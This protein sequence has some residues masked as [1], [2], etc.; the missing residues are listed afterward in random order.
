MVFAGPSRLTGPVLPQFSE[1]ETEVLDALKM[2]LGVS[3]D[4]IDDLFEQ[5]D[6][7]GQD[8]M[9][10]T[11]HMHIKEVEE[12]KDNMGGGIEVDIITGSVDKD[13]AMSDNE[14]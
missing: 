5:C 14:M 13:V 1:H 9:R 3:Q 4:K 8:F 2:G 6:H 11:F 10:S 7:C 12:T